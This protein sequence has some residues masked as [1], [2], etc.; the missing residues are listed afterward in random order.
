MDEHPLFASAASYMLIIPAMK[1][2]AAGLFSPISTQVVDIVSVQ[3]DT[4][5][6]THLE[7]MHL[8]QSSN[9]SIN[10]L[11]PVIKQ[12]CDF[13]EWETNPVFGLHPRPGIV[14]NLVLDNLTA[15][16]GTKN[17]ISDGVIEA[18]VP[19]IAVD[20]Q[21]DPI[22]SSDFNLSIRGIGIGNGGGMTFDWVCATERCSQRD[23]H[24]AFLG[25]EIPSYSGEVSVNMGG[26]RVP[27]SETVYSMY[28][29]DLTSLGGSI[30]SFR[31]MTPLPSTDDNTTL[32]ATPDTLNVTLPTVIATDCRRNLTIVNV[33]ATFTRPTAVDIEMGAYLL[34]WRPVSVD[35]ESIQ[36]VQPY[37][38]LQPWYFQPPMIEIGLYG[39][40]YDV[41]TVDGTLWSNSLWP[42][43]GS[44]QNFFELLAADAHHRV[45]N[46]S[47]LLS[48]AGLADS[49][50][51][52]YTAYCTQI[53]SELRTFASNASLA[54]SADQTVPAR[55][56]HSQLRVHQDARTTYILLALLGTVAC[57]AL[58]VFCRFPGDAIL[59]KEPGSIASRFSLLADSR[60]VRQ[61]RQEQV[62]EVNEIRKWR[63]PAALGWWR[64]IPRTVSDT[65]DRSL[66]STWRWGV[67]IGRDV[68]L[69]SWKDTPR[70]PPPASSSPSPSQ[71]STRS[72]LDSTPMLPELAFQPLADEV[73]P[74]E[75]DSQ[76]SS[77]SSINVE[78]LHDDGR[79]G[80]LSD[81][82]T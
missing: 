56:V 3:M 60:L 45:G 21:C 73:P 4:S 23:I 7:N 37:A 29:A 51:H 12:A 47:R 10:Y 66:T 41:D 36:F 18:R 79:R 58:L 9:S 31:N 32:W 40:T 5:L 14:G 67:D 20:I 15:V 75:T 74:T 2:V 69:Q 25:S 44:S 50:R 65:P 48:P 82:D 27:A 35:V 59:P 78:L 34:P 16:V 68:T 61:L 53:L 62:S 30:H 80:H 57:F 55:L 17:D 43:R 81:S 1:L 11:T 70:S 13:A 22:P 64:D 76:R 26:A 38:D 8:E 39:Q 72:S 28:I 77:I 63:E 24:V 52:M 33:N 49:A 54:P 42:A 71:S 46:L 6:T 19:A